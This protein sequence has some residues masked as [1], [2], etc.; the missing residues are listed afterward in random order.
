MLLSQ[1]MRKGRN[2]YIYRSVILSSFTYLLIILGMIIGAIR[3]PMPEEEEGVFIELESFLEENLQDIEDTQTD[4][5]ISSEERRNIA[6]NRALKDVDKT[7]PYDY[8]DVE[9]ADEAYKESLV[10]KALG[11]EEYKKIFERDDLN[12][13]EE[14]YE[15]EPQ[16]S[17]E[18]SKETPSNFQGATYITFFLKN[19]HK[20]KIPVPTYKCESSGKVIVNINVNRKGFVSSFDIDAKSTTDECL[21]KSAI[22]SVKQTKFNENYDAPLKQ[23][24][25]ITY[26]FE[27]Q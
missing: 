17:E 25:T 6:V 13:E 22:A 3:T 16:E 11:N 9:K 12:L 7:D 21:I 27:A 1:V 18:I 20:V 2:Y 8:S 14:N 4:E 10:K 24:G 15:E 23:R 5:N 19:R 26:V